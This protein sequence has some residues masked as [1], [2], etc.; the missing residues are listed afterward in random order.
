MPDVN[1]RRAEVFAEF[2]E[3]SIGLPRRARWPTFE[4]Q[5]NETDCGCNGES[6]NRERDWPREA[7]WFCGVQHYTFDPAALGV[8]FSGAIEQEHDHEEE[9]EEIRMTFCRKKLPPPTPDRRE[10]R[11]FP[12]EQS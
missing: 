9:Q 11:L 12:P 3:R 5:K 2:L 10:G 6:N 7:V 8:F 4:T 1:K